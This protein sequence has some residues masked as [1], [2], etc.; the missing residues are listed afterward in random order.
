VKIT[1][2]VGTPMAGYYYDRGADKIH[3][4]LFARALVIEKDGTKV[5]IVTCDLIGISAEIV[6]EVRKI[7][8]KSCGI[9]AEHVMISA[10]HA[11]TG[12]VIP[13]SKSRYNSTGKSAEILAGYIGKLPALIAQSVLEANEALQPAQLSFALGHEESISFNRRF[14]MTDGTVGWNPGKLNPKI[15]KPAGPIDPDVSVLYSETLTGKP[16][17]TFVN[18]ALHLD[19]VGGT[20]ISADM[21]FT[22]SNILQNFKGSQMVTVFSQGCSGNIN[23][24]NVKSA[25]PQQGQGEAQRIGT[26]LAGEVIKTYTKLCAL[27]IKDIRAKSLIVKLPLPEVSAADIPA[28]QGIISQYG[29]Q[30]AAPFF[31]FVKAF[32]MVE[33][34]E[35]KG[36]PID[37]EIQVFALGDSCAIVS[38]PAEIFTELGMYIKSRS[39]FANTIIVELANGSIGYVPDRK[40]FIEGSYEPLS[41][42]VAPGSGEILAEKALEMLNN[43]KRKDSKSN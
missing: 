38:L 32:K 18:F 19:N 13:T 7:I 5:A 17:L 15:I 2:P 28:A 43:L 6:A 3:D 20:E 23:H 1:P 35:R 39:P 12:P 21:P 40:A 41:S 27:N 9:D 42:R 37:A 25:V 30:D 14:F 11:H 8:E 10:T 16:I 26:V 4:D 34:Y 22:L 31:D 36:K 29:K 24:I 33:V